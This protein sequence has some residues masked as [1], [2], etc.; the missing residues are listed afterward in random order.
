MGD[1]SIHLSSHN[2]AYV[3]ELFEAWSRQPDSVPEYW[4]AIF[5]AQSP[6]GAD[7]SE[8]PANRPSNGRQPRGYFAARA[9]GREAPA[10]NGNGRTR[11]APTRKS[12][13]SNGSPGALLPTVGTAPDAQTAAPSTPA[14]TPQAVLDLQHRVDQLIRN[15]RVRGHRIAQLD[16][17]GQPRHSPPELDPAFYGLTDQDMDRVF[18]MSSSRRNQRTLTLRQIISLLQNTYCRYIGVQ[19]MHI[20]D[21]EMREWLQERMEGTENRIHLDRP[22]QLRILTRL[23]DAVIFEQFVQKKYLGAKT[24]SLEGGESLIPLL[25]MAIEKAGGQ[26]VRE[27]VMAM[28]HRGRLNVLA[29]IL[30][31]SAKQIFREFEDSDHASLLGRGDVKYHMGHSSDWT[32][33][34][35]EKVHL[36]LCFNPSHLEYINPVA[37]G[38]MRAKMDR[39]GP[40]WRQKG[41]VVLIHGDAAFA[42]EGIVPETLNLSE[43]PGYDTGGALHII[44]NNQ[45]GFTTG[46]QQARSTLYATSVAKMLAS[47]IFHVNG[48]DPEAVAQA[49]Q[50][51]LD[52]RRQFGRDAFIDMYCY[53]KRGHNEGDEPSFTQPR[54]YKA[55][56][57]RKG[58]REGYLEHLLKLGGISEDEANAIAEQRLEHLESELTAARSASSA[59][60]AKKPPSVWNVYQGGHEADVP[61]VDTTVAANELKHLLKQLCAVPQDF[62]VHPKIRRLLDQRLEMAESKRPL[63]WAA[64]EAL[65]YASLAVEGWRIRMSGQDCERGTFSHRHAVLHDIEDDRTWPVFQ[66]LS[67]T[68]SPVEF[69]NSPLSEAGVLGFEY[70]YSLDRPDGLTLWEAQFGDFINA[71]Q[72]IVDQFIASGEDK[73]NRLSGLVVLLPHG[74]EGQGPEHSSGRLERLLLLAADDNIQVT[75][76]TTPA[77]IFHLLRRQVLRTWRKPLF[78]MTPKSMLRLPAATSSLAEF[79]GRFQRIIPDDVSGRDDQ[80]R[81]VILCTGKIHYELAEQRK[82]LEKESQVAIIR[83]EQLHPLTE[84]ALMAALEPYPPGA[85]VFWVQEEPGNMGAWRYMKV[86]FGD[87]LN[88]RTGG[89]FRGLMRPDSASPATG[90]AKAHRTEQDRILED[91]FAEVG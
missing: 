37:L 23:T 33:A 76:P 31:K 3:E 63:D 55:I 26:G 19:Y 7:P 1:P 39:G 72:V 47:P 90:S 86:R 69:Y 41:L 79:E 62:N 43:L 13:G 28:A 89:R 87:A 36:S 8:S 78:I 74:F 11:P 27:I 64:G 16:P 54:L 73:W 51:S 82:Q 21:L 15:I 61:E 50:L 56:G 68:Q 53:R 67:E 2:L 75:Y 32:T 45:I 58:V 6:E 40:G 24:F 30:G 22:Q 77:Q 9:L 35:G 60:A 84:D 65:A 49:L 66:N 52:F 83:L 34:R 48:E 88:A 80:V 85:E 71:A 57:Q 81:R 42:G 18:T 44:V 29:N 46:P 20:D 17:L 12:E 4:Q 10:I 91:A 14:A 38:R 5:E 70:G 25:E 59:T